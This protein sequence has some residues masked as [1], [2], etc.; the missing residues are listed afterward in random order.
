MTSTTESSQIHISNLDLFPHFQT[1]FTV[2]FYS[3]F[4]PDCP[5][6]H[7]NTSKGD[8]R[9][10]QHPLCLLKSLSC[11]CP[12]VCSDTHTR[13][14][15]PD[16]PHSLIYMTKLS[17]TDINSPPGL[18][19][20]VSPLCIP[21]T[22]VQPSVLFL[23]HSWLPSQPPQSILPTKAKSNHITLSFSLPDDV[24]RTP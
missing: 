4:P 10:P 17:L 18:C 9:F 7:L 14:L 16:K 3:I 23:S 24:P 5:H 21:I 12:F 11:K 8:L 15:A 2:T 19:I 22:L 1:V 13:Y 20:M 6:K